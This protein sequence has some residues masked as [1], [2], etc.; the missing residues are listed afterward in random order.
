MP[1]PHTSEAVFRFGEF[2]ADLRARELHR[3][4]ALVPLQDQPFHLLALL[5]ERPGDVVTRE[6][7][8]LLLW[9]DDIF[10]DFDHGLNTAMKKLRDALADS[11]QSPHFVETLPKRGYRFLVPVQRVAVRQAASPAPPAQAP[12]SA[13]LSAAEDRRGARQRALRL[14][15]LVLLAGGA[16][17][18]A[19]LA[20]RPREWRAGMQGAREVANVRS[21]AVLPLEDLS[22]GGP[23]FGDAITEALTTDLARTKGMHVISRHSSNTFR[24][25]RRTPAEIGRDLKVDALVEGSVQSV[26]DRLR[27]D[28]RLIGTSSGEQMWAQRF[29][30]TAANVFA[31]EDRASRGLRLALA[32]SPGEERAQ[33]PPTSNSEAYESYLRGKIRVRR[34]NEEDNSAAISL[35]EH[36]VA[37]DPGFAAAQAELSHAYA[38]RVTQFAP[39]DA[40][41]LERAHLAAEKALRSERD[42]AEGH[43]AAGFL[44][45]GIVPGQFEYERAV[46]ELRRAIA[47]NGNLDEAHHQLGMIYLHIG[48]IDEAVA[49]FREAMALNPVPTNNN[50]LRRIGIAL[51]YRGQ[52]QEGL[53]IFQQVPPESNSALWNYQ[54][55]WALL[56]LAR[57]QE[58]WEL[59]ERYLTAHPEDRGGVVTST[60]AIWFAKAGDARRAEADIR[61]AIERGKGFVHFHHTAYN[62]ASAYALLGQ[63]GPASRW[64]R[65]AAETGWPC[66]PYF[67]N[68]PNLERIRGH[69]SY[70]A[71]IRELKQEWERYRA[72][73]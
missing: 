3:G 55:A 27:V 16:L 21:L 53:K 67:A 35:F 38:L 33:T 6:E 48:L 7:I 59:I 49:E 11:A 64:L 63:A 61:T 23:P 73:L 34:E 44:L 13:A 15:G 1:E 37:M 18:A 17:L 39:N 45:W 8:R 56:Y 58:A 47:L 20:I 4:G 60:R 46:R 41:A 50:P 54:V 40:S 29:E 69:A 32:S 2:E 71:F 65:V 14:A 36:A 24:S 9:S 42:L 30:G 68:D 10:V 19:V 72:T 51:I 62:I 31:L 22:A 66:Y 26:G 57:N 12:P 52:Y 5:L 25:T 28:L 70:L 43:Y